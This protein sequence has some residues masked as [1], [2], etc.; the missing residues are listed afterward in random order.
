L[1]LFCDLRRDQLVGHQHDICL[2]AGNSEER[3]LAVIPHRAADVGAWAS[4]LR[5]RFQDRPVVVCLKLAKGSLIYALQKYDFLPSS[6]RPGEMPRS[7]RAE[8]I[9]WPVTRMTARTLLL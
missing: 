6:G 8:S 7:V 1:Y 5:Q 2:Q 3:E 9:G 4:A